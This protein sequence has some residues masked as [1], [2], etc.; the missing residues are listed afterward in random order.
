MI[1]SILTKLFAT[2]FMAYEKTQEEEKLIQ[3]TQLI[4][5]TV[6]QSRMPE[7]TFH[8]FCALG[9]G[10]LLSGNLPQIALLHSEATFSPAH[11]TSLQ[12]YCC[13]KSKVWGTQQKANNITSHL[14]QPLCMEFWVCSIWQGEMLRVKGLPSPN[15][16]T[17][18][19]LIGTTW[20]LISYNI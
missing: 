18:G 7:H 20:M 6:A 9:T 13:G 3:S 1:S 15:I 11:W 16:A 17:E 12:G 19:Q 4:T 14:S 10:A 8:P 5:S 2:L